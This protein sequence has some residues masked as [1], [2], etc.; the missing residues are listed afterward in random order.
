[1]N[2]LHIENDNIT[3]KKKLRVKKNRENYVHSD[4]NC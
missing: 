1:M 3:I 4:V 2:I